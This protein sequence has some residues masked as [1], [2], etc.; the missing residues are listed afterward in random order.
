MVIESLL[1]RLPAVDVSNDAT[2]TSISIQTDDA[3]PQVFVNSVVGAKAY[4]TSEAQLGWTGT[5]LI[6]VG[7]LIQ[8]TIGG[9]S[10]DASTVC[11]VICKYRS[12]VS[13]G[14]L[15]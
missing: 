3:T 10:A 9:G 12:I 14:Y 6:K 1:I 11:D 15:N 2:I 13:G 5:S 7:T 4:L 8:L